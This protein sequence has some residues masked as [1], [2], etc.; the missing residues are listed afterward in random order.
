MKT[1]HL[2]VNQLSAHT[3]QKYLSYLEAMDNK[4]IETYGTFLAENVEM[5]LNNHPFGKGKDV[6][7]K[8]L[9]EYWQSFATIEHD[10]TNIYGTDKNFVLEAQNHY[11]RHDGELATI[12]A[13]AFTDMDDMGK[14][15]S[16]R[17]YM[18]M[19][20]VFE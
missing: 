14:V 19:A 18:D 7:L 2:R 4:D 17:L 1:K 15:R 16:V 20:P 5:W 3:Y 10:L 6:I 9:E 8:G 12:K 11:K 13:V